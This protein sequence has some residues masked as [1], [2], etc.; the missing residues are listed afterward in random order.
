MSISRGEAPRRDGEAK[1]RGRSSEAALT[2]LRINIYTYRHLHILT[3][4]YIHIHTHTY[5]HKYFSYVHYTYKLYIHIIRIC[6]ADTYTYNGAS[7][8]L[9]RQIH[10]IIYTYTLSQIF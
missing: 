1:N 10:I 7:R 6:Y 4:T 2:Y 3:Y 9:L 8:S 5:V